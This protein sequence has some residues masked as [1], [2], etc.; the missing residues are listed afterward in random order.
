MPYG[1]QGNSANQRA[2]QN[3]TRFFVYFKKIACTQGS[4]KYSGHRGN[5]HR[6]SSKDTWWGKHHPLQTVAV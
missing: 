1:I 6:Y 3:G 2:R 5:F 4:K